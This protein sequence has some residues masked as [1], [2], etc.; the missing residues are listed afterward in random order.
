MTVVGVVVPAPTTVDAV[1]RPEGCADSL[2]TLTSADDHCAGEACARKDDR[3]RD[4]YEL[5]EGS[6]AE[7]LADGELCQKEILCASVC[8][9]NTNRCVF[10]EEVNLTALC[11]LLT[12][13]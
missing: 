10:E 4:L 11:A 12:G 7:L 13:V 5:S 2:P 6:C 1:V 9:T 8:D 3:E